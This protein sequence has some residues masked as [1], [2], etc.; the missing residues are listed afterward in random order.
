[1]ILKLEDQKIVGLNFCWWSS[2]VRSCFVWHSV[3]LAKRSGGFGT[4]NC[5]FAQCLLVAQCFYSHFPLPFFLGAVM[6]WFYLKLLYGSLFSISLNF[7]I[8]LFFCSFDKL[9]KVSIE[10][11]NSSH[12]LNRGES[13]AN[14]L[15]L[16]ISDVKSDLCHLI[17]Y[18]AVLVAVSFIFPKIFIRSIV[19]QKPINPPYQQMCCYWLVLF[20]AH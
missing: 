20:Y 15:P 3:L 9:P 11:L 18:V 4:L 12:C 16:T 10:S 7:S 19:F 1:M 5:L 17:C 14:S 13:P 2:S 6:G 8:A